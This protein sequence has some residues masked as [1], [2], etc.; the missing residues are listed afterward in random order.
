MKRIIVLAFICVMSVIIAPLTAHSSWSNLSMSGNVAYKVSGDEVTFWV[1][2]IDN[3]NFIFTS[4]PLKLKLVAT[5]NPY[6]DAD[7]EDYI[8]LATYE[9]GAFNRRSYRTNIEVTTEFSPPPPDS[10][11][12]QWY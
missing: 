6:F 2:R 10:I 5:E 8:I 7:D 9:L 11:L 1:E 4:G 12:S 3:N